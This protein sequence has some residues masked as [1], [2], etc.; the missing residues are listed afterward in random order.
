MLRQEYDKA[1]KYLQA[2]LLVEELPKAQGLLIG[3][4]IHLEKFENALVG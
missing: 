1:A 4:C 3:A 2:A